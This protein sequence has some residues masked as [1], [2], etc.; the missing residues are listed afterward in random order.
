MW[1][2]SQTFVK[3]NEQRGLSLVW[4]HWWKEGSGLDILLSSPED[5]SSKMGI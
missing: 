2:I 5:K 1:R 3:E 4:N